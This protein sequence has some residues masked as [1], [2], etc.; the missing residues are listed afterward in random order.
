MNV[1]TKNMDIVFKLKKGHKDPING[2]F[3]FNNTP[4]FYN[5]VPAG[6]TLKIKDLKILEKLPIDLE[7]SFAI[8]HEKNVVSTESSVNKFYANQ[9]HLKKTIEVDATHYLL[10]LARPKTEPTEDVEEHVIV[11]IEVTS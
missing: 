5:R 4:D 2:V 6:N 11:E 1:E 7:I 8:D 3:D 9:S 10:V